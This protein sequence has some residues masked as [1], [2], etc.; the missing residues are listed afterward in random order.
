MNGKTVFSFFAQKTARETV[1]TEERLNVAAA[2]PADDIL[3]RYRTT[4]RGLASQAHVEA[5]RARWG[6]NRIAQGRKKSLFMRLARA[7]INP[8]TAI[9]TALAVISFFTDIVLPATDEQDFMTVAVISTMVL[10]SGILRFCQETRSDRAAEKLANMVENT[11]CVLRQNGGWQEIPME[12]I[13]AGDIVRLAAGD[14]VPA[15]CRI[16]QAKDLFISQSAMTGESEPV[17]KTAGQIVPEKGMAITGIANLAFMGSNVVSGT[18]LA[19]VVVTGEKTL[20][21]SLAGSLDARREATGFEKGLR[22]VSWLL[23]RFML[24]MVPVVFI[25]NGITK[26]DWLQALLFAISI[27]VGLTPEMLPMIVTTCLAKGAVA[28]SRKKTVI[29]NLGAI[30]NLGAM[31]VFC[32]DKT[33]TLTCDRV[34]LERHLDIHGQEDSRV[35]AFAFLNSFYQT[36]LKNLMDISIIERTNEA[37][38]NDPVLRRL[39]GGYT[40]IDEIP[41]DFERRRMSVAVTRVTGGTLLVTKGAVEEMLT[42]CR[43]VQYCGQTVLLTDDIIREIRETVRKLNDDGMRVIAVARKNYETAAP[44]FCVADESDMILTGYLAFLDPPRESARAAIAALHAYGV[45][46]KILTGDNERVTRAIC[47][48]VGL[49]T[50]RILTGSDVEEMDDTRLA[51]EIETADIFARLSPRQKTRIVSALRRNGHIVGYMGDGINDAS[52]MKAADVGISVDTA[53]DIAKE[54]ADVVLLEKNLMVLEE[55]VIEGRKIYGNMIKYIKMTTSSNFGNM[56]SVLAASFFLPFLP[57]AA[58]QIILLNLIYDTVNIALPWDNV[59]KAFLARPRRWQALSIGRF[60]LKIGPISSVFDIATFALMYFIVCP[61]VFGGSFHALDPVRQAGFIALFQAGWFI[62]SMWTQTLVMQ[63]I[64][65][66]GIPFVQSRASVA[67]LLASLAGVAL[68]SGIPFTVFGE[69]IGLEPLPAVYFAWLFA[70][71]GSYLA[72]VT[73]AKKAYI[74]KYREW[75]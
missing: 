51:V 50:G 23:I 24:V 40:K 42:V 19:I 70:M 38:A 5:N 39:S 52:A 13:V 22:S 20:F 8:F 55:G 17:E 3:R 6:D 53:V 67:V 68:A 45:G 60:M 73:L 49:P 66:A 48:Q 18:A 27:A 15:D 25:V 61:A 26:G 16:L 58:V 46:V 57:M 12:N 63:T 69:A 29:K 32:T 7:F 37:C 62:E 75:L 33:G 72:L 41:F 9:L 54:S 74:R 21:G 10:L 14:M 64:R 43:Y 31:D 1:A 59:D 71:T 35:L 65:T 2:L 4:I 47:R 36:G 56:F 44:D 30:Q 11:A 34:V 28:M